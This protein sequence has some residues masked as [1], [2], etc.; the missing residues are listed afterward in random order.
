MK[1][2]ILIL[3]GMAFLLQDCQVE[4]NNDGNIDYTKYVNPFIGTGS[5]D[6]LSL[7]GSNFPELACPSVWCN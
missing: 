4:Q 6:S 7:S 5:V 3:I 1:K 2:F